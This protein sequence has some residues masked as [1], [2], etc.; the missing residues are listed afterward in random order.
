MEKTHYNRLKI[1]LAEKE[2]TETWLSEQMGRNVGTVSRW[3]TNKVQPSVEQFHDMAN[4][5]DVDVKDFF[6]VIELF[7]NITI[8][9]KIRFTILTFLLLLINFAYG[10]KVG[11][12]SEFES[13]QEIRNYLANNV[14]LLDPLEGEY[15]TD[16]YGE[17]ITPLVHQY[18]PHS[19]WK[20]FIVSNNGK[21]NVYGSVDNH[22]SIS[23]LDV[24]PIGDTNAYW[25][26]FY[27]TS[28]RIYLQNNI[29]FSAAFKLDNASAKKHTKN[30]R[31]SPSVN[32][33]LY[34]DCVKTYPTAAMYANAAKK[35]I[36]ESQPKEWTG[37]GFALT[38]NYIVTN[39]HVV[40]G[41][42]SI[43]V[44]GINGD[45]NHKYSAEVI[46][47]DKVND[48]AIIK[49]KGINIQSNSI[50]YAVKT[51]TSEVGEE[52]FV[53][54]YPLT[55]TMG[56]E[57]KLTTGVISSKTGFQGDVSIYQISAPI[58][59]GN[60]GGPLFDSKG[61]V[62]GIVSAKHK[63]AENVGYAIKTSYL[64]NLMESAVATNILPQANKMAGQNLSG[65]V[66]MAKNFVYYITCSSRGFIDNNLSSSNNI[67]TSKK[68][69]NTRKTGYRI[70]V[71]TG[72]NSTMARKKAEEVKKEIEQLLLGTPVY[73]HFYNPNWIC[74]IGN[75]LTVEDA[76]IVLNQIKKHGYEDSKIVKGV[77]STN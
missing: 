35:A 7:K 29:Q 68:T 19:K 51:G 3:M 2:K 5:L 59:P 4:H 6:G 23:K 42:K 17:Y 11:Y 38:N 27:S 66:K 50:P 73:V 58:Q 64:K 67:S 55:S 31:L 62:I 22:F 56:E 30:P 36:E 75:F 40:D 39:N 61:N 49:V 72:D 13:E 44:Q 60:S 77:I 47:T 76:N 41:A 16:S 71:F 26:K 1:V 53:L 21:F 46:S 14:A 43:N 45:F 69:P 70:Q 54:G 28:T 25:M 20:M 33:I 18:Y 32:V 10:Q 74:R 63:G 12:K 24:E 15:D 65:K 57:I 34:N 37:T 52:V 48:L 9:M 8:I